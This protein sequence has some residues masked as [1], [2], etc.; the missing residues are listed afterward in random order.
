MI[1]IQQLFL[2][3]WFNE[4]GF[5]FSKLSVEAETLAVASVDMNIEVW[6]PRC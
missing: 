4:F 3:V 2:V 6:R 1:H 5:F